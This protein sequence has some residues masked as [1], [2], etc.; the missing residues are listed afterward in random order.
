MQRNRYVIQRIIGR[1]AQKEKLE[2]V[3]SGR[4][5]KQKVLVLSGLHLHLQTN[6][7]EWH[8]VGKVAVPD[9]QTGTQ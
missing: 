2:W 4:C 9:V 3:L 6:R 8:R 1:C 5:V 7:S